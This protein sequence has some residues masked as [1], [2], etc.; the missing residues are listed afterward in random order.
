MTRSSFPRGDDMADRQSSAS[1]MQLLT[2]RVRN[3][4]PG[5]DVTEKRMFGGTTF[6]LNGNM[7]CCASNKGL[8]VRVGKEAEPKALAR[9]HAKPCLGAGRRMAG[10]IMVAFEGISNKD[11]LAAWLDM[12]MNYVSIL[13]PKAPSAKRRP[14]PRIPA[15]RI[16]HSR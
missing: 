2:E 5:V 16:R 10:F 6:L 13:P 11:R 15:P 9:P 14:K 8:M 1:K 3:A 12:A 4:L 7:L